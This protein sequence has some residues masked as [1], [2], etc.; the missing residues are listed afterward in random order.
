M[1]AWRDAGLSY[2]RYANICAILT[3]RAVKE[4]F[5]A[6]A[7]ERDFA[8]MKVEQWIAGKCFF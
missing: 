6:R 1:S 3:R 8:N 7:L 2:L 4:P 5:L